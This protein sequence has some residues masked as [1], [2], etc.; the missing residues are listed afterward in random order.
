MILLLPTTI[1][2]AVIIRRNNA[3]EYRSADMLRRDILAAGIVAQ[4]CDF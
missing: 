4:N 1:C 2:W 3:I